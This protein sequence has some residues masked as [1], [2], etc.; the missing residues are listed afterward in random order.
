MNLEGLRLGES[1]RKDYRH[2]QGYL[3]EASGC[4]A[5]PTEVLGC[6]VDEWQRRMKFSEVVTQTLGW[7]QREGRVSYRA[8]R[9]EFD[10]D[11]HVLDALKEELIEIKELA[12]DKDGK[13][14]VWTGTLTETPAR[15]EERPK[16]AAPLPLL[17]ARGHR[18]AGSPHDSA[19]SPRCQNY[20][21]TAE[22]DCKVMGERAWCAPMASNADYFV[23][24]T[25]V[26]HLPTSL[27][28]FL[29][30]NERRIFLRDSDT[31]TSPRR[32]VPG[33]TV[34]LDVAS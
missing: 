6:P 5:P 31:S 21:T 24:I 12:V 13:M 19:T 4:P 29:D 20:L 30:V 16:T 22:I 9:L 17:A 26:V 15:S 10:L 8:L 25:G 28:V 14:P 27:G 33:E 11:D 1:A 34:T 3:Q 7:L 23:L 2:D 32:F 18:L